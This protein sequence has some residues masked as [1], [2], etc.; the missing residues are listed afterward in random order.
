M[1][2]LPNSK[3]DPRTFSRI[4]TPPFAAPSLSS[5]CV[6]LIEKSAFAS[7]WLSLVGTYSFGLFLTHQPLVTWLG[8]RIKSLPVWEFLLLSV[9]VLWVLSAGSIALEKAVNALTDRLYAARK[10]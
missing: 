3:R 5:G 10:S 7:K 1:R 6:G 4:V 9:G 2:S 8:Q